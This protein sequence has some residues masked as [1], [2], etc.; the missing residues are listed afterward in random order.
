MI[1][2]VKKN[3]YAKEEAGIFLIDEHW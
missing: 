3:R 1:L 2:K